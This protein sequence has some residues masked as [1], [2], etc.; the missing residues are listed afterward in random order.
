MSGFRELLPTI[1]T[2]SL[3]FVFED[4]AAEMLS[5]VEVALI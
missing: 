2:S 5:A 3:Y 4:A 1:S